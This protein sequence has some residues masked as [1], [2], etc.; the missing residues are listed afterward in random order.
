MNL[1]SRR[2]F[3]SSLTSQSSI[4]E[5]VQN[6]LVSELLAPSDAVWLVSPWITNVSIL[7]NRSGSFDILNPQW[8]HR[9]I[10]LL[11]IMLLVLTAGTRCRIVTRPLEVNERFLNQINEAAIQNGVGDS[12]TVIQREVLHT[13][14]FLTSRGL[15]IGSMNFTYSGLE[16]NDESVEFTVDR[17]SIASARLAFE[18]Y[19]QK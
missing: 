9:E 16:L 18:T 17:Q 11:D 8:G 14:G 3:K 4:R 6:V 19:L 12:L 13:K 1:L 7:D 15:L 10:R 2:I 5:L